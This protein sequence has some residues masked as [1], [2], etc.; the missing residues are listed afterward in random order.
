MYYS[1]ITRG[2]VSE[3]EA[4]LQIIALCERW[5]YSVHPNGD[6]VK[7][8]KKH[9]DHLLCIDQWNCFKQIRE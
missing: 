2:G 3:A 6:F 7:Y 1:E 8:F 9:S 5:Y 4:H